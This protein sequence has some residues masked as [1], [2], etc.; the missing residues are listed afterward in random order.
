LNSRKD[1][2]R[3]IAAKALAFLLSALKESGETVDVDELLRN[4]SVALE[5]LPGDGYQTARH[6]VAVL[7]NC[8]GARYSLDNYPLEPLP[9]ETV[10]DAEVNA[11]IEELVRRVRELA[12]V[13]PRAALDLLH[14]RRA[15]GTQ[16]EREGAK[17]VLGTG[18]LAVCTNDGA[19]P[20]T[21]GLG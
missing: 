14:G 12:M 7:G 1:P 2:A 20:R 13:T 4:V 17:R 6:C 19:Y 11:T 3:G 15:S 9:L 16:R 18:T 21:T 5:L 8:Y 10:T